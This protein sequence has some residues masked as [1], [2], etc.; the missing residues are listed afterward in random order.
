MTDKTDDGGPA[1]P[2]HETPE[3]TD[4]HGMTL[5]QYFAA[6]A[7][8]G[9]LAAMNAMTNTPDGGLCMAISDDDLDANV[10]H[11]YRIADAMIRAGAAK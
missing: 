6:K 4:Y 10:R 9:E 8:Q 7:M 11:W 1:F 3:S 2:V 5:R